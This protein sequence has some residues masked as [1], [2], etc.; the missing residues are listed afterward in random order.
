M[1]LVAPGLGQHVGALEAGALERYA[2][3]GEAGREAQPTD[4]G[5]MISYVRGSFRTPSWW[6]PE[7]CANAF[8]PT[9]ALFGCTGMPVRSDTRRLVGTI[10]SV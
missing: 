7:A 8:A 2:E 3:L 4:S 9:T 1:H 10:F 6:I 5:V